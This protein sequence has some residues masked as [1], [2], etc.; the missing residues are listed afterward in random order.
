MEPR[1]LVI[2]GCIIEAAGLLWIARK[3]ESLE[4]YTPTIDKFPLGFIFEAAG[5]YQK[6]V[7]Y[8]LYQIILVGLGIIF[9]ILSLFS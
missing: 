5:D 3:Y 8:F 2:E 6:E 7:K 1:I 9:Q 4:E